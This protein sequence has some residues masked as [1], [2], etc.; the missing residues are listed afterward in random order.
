MKILITG[1]A[2]YLGRGLIK[3]FEGKHQ[4][5][6]MDVVD[7]ETPHEK[8]IGS[9]ADLESVRNAAKGMDAI[10][11]AHMAPRQAGAYETPVLPFDVNVKGTANLFSAAVE[12]K[13][14]RVCLISSHAAVSGHPDAMFKT[15]D[16]PV[17]GKTMYCLSKV[18]QEIIAE[19]YYRNHGIKVAIERMAWIVD[20]DSRVSKYGEKLPH[21]ALGMVDPRDMGEVARLAL[22]LPDLGYEVFYVAGVP[23]S[24]KGMD[25]DYT[26]RR[27]NW[28]PK[29]DFRDWPTFEEWEKQQGK[30]T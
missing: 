6:L 1:A 20:A 22:E 19:H 10:I 18:C 11:I 13:I 21:R 15:R 4:L 12:E 23:G 8:V 28:K 2:G 9:V 17:R 14:Q 29:Y 30:S 27:L 26:H 3:P 24:E 7:F 16:L 25:T 5:R